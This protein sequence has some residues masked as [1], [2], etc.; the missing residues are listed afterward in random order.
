MAAITKKLLA[1]LA[2]IDTPTIC[3]T[4][5]I[6]DI[7]QASKGFISQPFVC[8]DP[9]AK[10]I[11]GFAKTAT[12]RAV[13]PS[14]L[15]S[16]DSAALTSS[17]FDYLAA[18]PSPNICVMQDL[19]GERAGFGAMWGEVNSNIH[20]VLGCLG[21]VTN[22]SVRDVDM[23]ADGFQAIA[24]LIGPSH[25]HVHYVDFGLDVQVLGMWV[26]DG[27][28]VHADGHGAVVIPQ[29]IAHLIPE[30]AALQARREA[31]IL[32]ACKAPGF[33]LAKLKTAY[34]AASK[35]N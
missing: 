1:Q 11:V 13:E 35:V 7:G 17:Y 18:K 4:M 26:K 22:G 6:L 29:D 16:K 27:D 23:W 5:D 10:P 14:S 3:N 2:E 9:E 30:T 21:L 12:C 34:K 20:K 19:D 33:T 8:L 32:D 15:S 24:G 25:A 28:L 31:V